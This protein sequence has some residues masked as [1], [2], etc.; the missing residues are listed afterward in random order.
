MGYSRSRIVDA[1]DPDRVLALTEGQG[2][3]IGT[4]PEGLER[5]EVDR[6]GRA[7]HWAV[8]PST[9]MSAPVM[10]PPISLASR[11]AM[12]ATSSTLFSRLIA[13]SCA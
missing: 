8:P 1:D 5:M 12:A 4:P 6:R 7:H 10:P 3:S 11:V 13:D 9:L 2:V